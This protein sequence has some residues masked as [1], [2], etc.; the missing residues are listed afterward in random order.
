ML[1]LYVRALASHITRY[2]DS[3][4][5]IFIGKMRPDEAIARLGGASVSDRRRLRR[6]VPMLLDH[7]V[8][9]VADGYL[10]LL[11]FDPA[12]ETWSKAAYPQVHARDHETCRYC[13]ATDQVSVDH[14][15]PRVQ[16]GS[17]DLCNLALACK[18]CNSRKGGRTPEQAGMV[19]R[20]APGGA[21][22]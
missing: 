3:Y 9:G 19:L 6:E 14:V 2:A 16:G 13:G 15:L 4:G 20:P 10:Y 7:G 18:S 1:P 8:L 5:R 12:R 21:A 11:L 17:D 22:C